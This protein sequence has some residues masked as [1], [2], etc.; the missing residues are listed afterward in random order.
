MDPPPQPPGLKGGGATSSDA[1]ATS[2]AP[3][4]QTRSKTQL[5]SI[6][7]VNNAAEG[8]QHLKKAS[9]IPPGAEVSAK[10]LVTSLLTIA[11]TKGVAS[12]TKSTVR[13]VAFILEELVMEKEK[14]LLTEEMKVQ[15]EKEH[16]KL[17]I[18]MKSAIEEVKTT[19][20]NN[21]TETCKLMDEAVARNAQNVQP[22][23]PSY[24]DALALNI[25]TDKVSATDP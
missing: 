14:S 4:Q 24:R 8:R 10:S 25:S 6:S 22:T 15:L 21:I 20:E 17:S 13:S 11:E 23:I 12:A 2:S 19:I 3:S 7:N 9:I 5:T 18:I 1:G 16:D